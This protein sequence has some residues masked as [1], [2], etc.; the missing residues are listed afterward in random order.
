MNKYTKYIADARLED[1]YAAAVAEDDRAMARNAALAT[2][3]NVAIAAAMAMPQKS[4]YQRFLR[5]KAIDQEYDTPVNL[6][7]T[8]SAELY[9]MRR[10]DSRLKDDHRVYVAP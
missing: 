2:A 6:E 5:Q 4:E 7:G 8:N 9:A 10:A 3:R 1:G